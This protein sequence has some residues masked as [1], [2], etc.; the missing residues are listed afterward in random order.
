VHRSVWLYIGAGCG[1]LVGLFFLAILFNGV[2]STCRR[3]E[4]PPPSPK[5]PHTR[6]V[7]QELIMIRARPENHYK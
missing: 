4:S 7:Q 6:T 5:S 3:S 2:V 1:A